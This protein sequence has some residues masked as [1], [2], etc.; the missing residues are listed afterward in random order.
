M[1]QSLLALAI[2]MATFVFGQSRIIGGQT[3]TIDQY[4]HQV[5]LM[6]ASG[7]AQFCGGSIIDS[8]TILTASHCLTDNSASDIS[9]AYGVDRL[10]QGLT[11]IMVSEIIM[12]PDY[13]TRTQE[14]DI[15]ILKLETPIPLSETA[16]IIPIVTQEDED[17]GV[18][19]PGVDATITGWGNTSTGQNFVAPDQLQVV[20]VPIVSNNQA[21]GNNSYQGQITE[22]ML[23]AGD[24]SVG[25]KDAC[26][27]DSG[28]PLIVIKDGQQVLAGVV[29]WGYGCADPNYPGVYA[30]V[31]HFEDW[32]YEEAGW[33]RED[34]NGEDSTDVGEPQEDRVCDYTTE[35][36]NI[37]GST[38]VETLADVNNNTTTGY[39]GG[40]NGYNDI[41]II[42]RFI[43]R[44]EIYLSGFKFHFGHAVDGGNQSQITFNVYGDDGSN[45][46]DLN[47][48]IY[49]TTVALSTIAADI[50]AG[51]STDIDFGAGKKI[52][53]N[54]FIGFMN[55]TGNGDEIAVK[56]G[57][58]DINSAITQVQ[59][60]SGMEMWA[61]DIE[62]NWTINRNLDVTAIHCHLGEAP[63]PD[64]TVTS[65]SDTT[66][67][68]GTDT[69]ITSGADTMINSGSDTTMT[70]GSDTTIN[71]NT[72][73][74]VISGTVDTITSSSSDTVYLTSTDTI[75]IN[76][77]TT[78]TVY[79]TITINNFD[80]VVVNT[81]DTFYIEISDTVTISNFDT[82]T[83]GNNDTI[84][85]HHYDTTII[86]NF[87]TITITEET[88]CD[89]DSIEIIMPDGK[90][91]T[92]A[93]GPL[94]DLSDYEIQGQDDEDDNVVGIES[95]NK[96]EITVYPN[97]TQGMIRFDG[98][99]FAENVRLFDESG[100]VYVNSQNVDWLDVSAL[101]AGMYFIE[102]QKD[103]AYSTHSFIKD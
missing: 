15:A 46:P 40:T 77:D 55:P 29:S 2:T 62:D 50:Q 76:N 10:S 84:I 82:L 72:D 32:I 28:G 61:F 17:N 90:I 38:K 54:Y 16:K 97:P 59:L 7:T 83:I 60:Q 93:N 44:E 78:F 26:Q 64:T 12:H 70:S 69:T 14:N 31:S 86:E 20:T 30:R 9:I 79:D 71:G 102:I 57:E 80:T 103:G 39:I 58:S 89:L 22:D 37:K 91:I 100:K 96:V 8:Q 63:E 74:T 98:I 68:S 33:D 1:K 19:N 99:D 47:K 13:D 52:N 24:M 25:G 101:S 5:A 92:V 95:A 23:C 36:T 48:I 49:T 85:I 51:R 87:D 53:G 56:T 35:F 18:I 6:N 42:E 67:S 81:T 41:A 11:R 45:L 43:N 88:P 3:T 73:T 27:G 4:P 65:G 75:V 94:I 66:V 34:G 21:N